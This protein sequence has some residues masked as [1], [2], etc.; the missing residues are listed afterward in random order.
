MQM[1]AN[2]ARDKVRFIYA[3][4]KKIFFKFFFELDPTNAVYM[5]AC[6]NSAV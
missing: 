6:L 1:S 3:K 2:K 5:S 4:K